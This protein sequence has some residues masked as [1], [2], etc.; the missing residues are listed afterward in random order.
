MNDFLVVLQQLS[1]YVDI[2]D[3]EH[4]DSDREL[5]IMVGSD[6]GLCGSLNAKLF[7][8][9]DARYVD[10]TSTLDVYSI[11]KKSTEHCKRNG[12]S[13]IDSLVL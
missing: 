5:L 10:K 8:A 11:G 13:M 2:F 7:K 6:K 4:V 9:V 3:A 1:S 12:Y